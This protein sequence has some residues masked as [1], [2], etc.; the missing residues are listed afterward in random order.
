MMTDTKSMNNSKNSIST[1][2]KN[3]NSKIKY[4]QN[5]SSNS[6]KNIIINTTNDNLSSKS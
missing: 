6:S 2:Y 3:S 1:D 4:D 5:S